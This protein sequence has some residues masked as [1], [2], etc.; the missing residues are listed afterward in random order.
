MGFRDLCKFNITFLVKQGWRFIVKPDSLAARI[1]K[2][3]HF[4]H[5]SFW[6]AHLRT[7]PSY[8]WRGIFATR[9]VLEDGAGW[10]VGSGI[11]ISIWRDSWLPI[12]VGGIRNTVEAEAIK[13]IPLSRSVD[14]D[15][16]VWRGDRSCEYFIR[17]GYRTLIDHQNT[18]ESSQDYSAVYKKLWLLDIPS[19]I[20]ITIW[21]LLHNMIPTAYI[22]YNR[23]ITP[24][25]LCLRC[26][27]FPKSAMHA[28]L[29]YGPANEVWSQLGLHWVTDHYCD[30]FWDW[31]AYVFQTN[32]A[33][34]CSKILTTMWLLW[35]ARN[36]YVMEGKQQSVQE[37]RTKIES[38]IMQ[39]SVIKE[40]LPKKQRSMSSK[41]LPPERVVVKI[42]LDATFKQNLRQFCSSFV[43]RND[44]GLVM[45][46]G[47][48]LNSNVADAFSAEALA[49]FQALT[50]AKEMGFSQV[51]IE[52]DSRIVEGS[53]I[54]L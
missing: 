20:K 17:S 5:I 2:A 30:S 23:Q 54:N 13:C 4:P 7:N 26:G 47:S 35:H 33:I 48:I 53:R 27:L 28:I 46:S 34:G 14:G 10:R 44:L 52:G 22:L 32:D 8:V 45:G 3:K 9:K 18:E 51:V 37:I 1:F 38:F 12:W 24:F 11:N 31:I 41:W 43:I 39:S 15:M 42:N 40:R 21:R 16:I 49:C 25:P 29:K 36:Q 19:K 6:S 50:F